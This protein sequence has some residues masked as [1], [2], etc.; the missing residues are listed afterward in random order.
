VG[1]WSKLVPWQNILQQ[2]RGSIPRIFRPQNFANWENSWRLINSIASIW[3]WK[4][5][6]IFVLG[7]Y[8]FLKAHRSPQATLWQNFSLLWTDLGQ[9]YDHIFVP[10]G[11]YCLYIPW[12]RWYLITKE[13]MLI[14]VALTKYK[15]EGTL[16]EGPRE[17]AGLEL[18]E[19]LLCAIIWL[20][21]LCACEEFKERKN[22]QLPLLYLAM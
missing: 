21:F 1:D 10:N 3:L 7:H 4:Y 16:W 20:E 2:K 11:S 5:A 12:S 17:W 19:P 22:N 18:T 13:R 8:P 14:Y 15:T 9:I 6:Q